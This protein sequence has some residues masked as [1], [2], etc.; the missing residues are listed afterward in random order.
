M[1]FKT[2]HIIRDGEDENALKRDFAYRLLHNPAKPQDAAVAVF[3]GPA[4]RMRA[5]QAATQWPQD[6]EVQA[7]AAELLKQHGAEHFL[8]S[9]EEVAR[10][11]LALAQNE[12]VDEKHRL[13]AYKLFGDYMGYL[14]GA[15]AT[16]DVGVGPMRDLMDK[17]AGKGRPK[18]ATST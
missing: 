5:M 13:D 7:I 11:I 6:T 2:T 8:P 10:E 12:E 16:I 17:V 18:P 14:K 3:P 1:T 15:T 9:K 4:N